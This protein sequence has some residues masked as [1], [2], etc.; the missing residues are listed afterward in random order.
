MPIEN[1]H[2]NGLQ[3]VGVICLD[4]GVSVILKTAALVFWKFKNMCFLVPSQRIPQ[5]L[6]LTIKCVFTTP[7][8]FLATWTMQV[9]NN[10]E[11]VQQKQWLMQGIIGPACW[12]FVKKI[13]W[14]S[15]CSHCHATAGP[16]QLQ[17]VNL[18][19]TDTSNWW[20]LHQMDGGHRKIDTNEASRWKR[21]TRGKDLDM[22]QAITK[23][24]TKDQELFSQETA[25][26][27]D[28]TDWTVLPEAT[29]RSS[30]FFEYGWKVRNQSSN[31]INDQRGLLHQLPVR[32]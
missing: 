18:L 3:V 12:S 2:V 16:T 27:A 8:P 14:G 11:F 21:F 5:S 30:K 19:K 32:F 20:E 25:P 13:W 6:H 24:F 15:H 17:V 26:M 29:A 31:W 1:R 22:R 28:W 4:M 10:C 7:N 23:D 9:R